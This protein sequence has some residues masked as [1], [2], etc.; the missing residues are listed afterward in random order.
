VFMTHMH[1]IRSGKKT[2]QG[3]EGSQEVMCLSG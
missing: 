2:R 3:K 1:R